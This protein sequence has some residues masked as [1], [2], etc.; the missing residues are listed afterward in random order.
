M[1]A[2]EKLDENKN[3]EQRNDDVSQMARQKT[4]VPKRQELSKEKLE[5]AQGNLS[6]IF[7]GRR[8]RV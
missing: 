8:F 4:V 1:H 7:G 6:N 5:D 3:R 2:L